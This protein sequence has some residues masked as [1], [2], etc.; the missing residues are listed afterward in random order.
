VSTRYGL[1]NAVPSIAGHLAH[2]HGGGIPGY[3]CDLL[4]VPDADLLIVILSNNMSV[5]PDRLARQIAEKA[6][7][8]L[9]PTPTVA[10]PAAS[11]DDYVGVYRMPELPTGRHIVSRDGDSL[12]LRSTGGEADALRPLGDDRFETVANRTSVRF[13]RDAAGEVATVEVDDGSGPMFKS[14]RTDEPIPA[15]RKVAALPATNYEDF[16]GHYQLMP[17]MLLEVTRETDRLYAQIPGQPRFEIFPESADHFFVKVVDAQLVFV[18]DGAGAVT[19][20]T[21]HQGGR[22]RPGPKVR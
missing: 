10:L 17:G 19:S 4:R 18:R 20:V 13:Q 11:L 6:L 9:P 12:R 15:E 1:G 3:V 2:E 5:S 21:L 7:G 8:G 22:E 16:V 14:P